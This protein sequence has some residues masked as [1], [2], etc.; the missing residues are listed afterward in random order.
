MKNIWE[1]PLNKAMM[2][3]ELL[4]ILIPIFMYVVDKIS[5]GIWNYFVLIEKNILLLFF[6]LNFFLFIHNLFTLTHRKINIIFRFF[7]LIFAF[8][9][10]RIVFNLMFLPLLWNWLGVLISSVFLAS[11]KISWYFN[12]LSGNAHCW[13][14][15]NFKYNSK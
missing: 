8:L 9:F 7:Y 12:L 13:R 11:R 14:L 1:D 15:F 3:F 4:I 5:V 2:R 10:L 6:F